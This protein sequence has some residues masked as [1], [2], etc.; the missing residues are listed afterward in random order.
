MI[1]L[2]SLFEEDITNESL[3]LRKEDRS[4][5]YNPDQKHVLYDALTPSPLNSSVELLL[6]NLSA[7]SI[8][9]G[10]FSTHVEEELAFILEG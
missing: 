4:T 7:S 9:Y 2:S 3:I 6:I 8:T 10:D 5:I 1:N